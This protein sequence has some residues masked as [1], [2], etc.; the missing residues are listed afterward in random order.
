MHDYGQFCPLAMAA[1]I[2][3]L[4]WMPLVIRELH[5]GSIRF[6]D[7]HRGIPRMSRSLLSR[8][9]GELE[10]AGL[11]ERRVVDGHPEYHPTRA[12]ED[13]RP[14]LAQLGAWGKRWIRSEISREHLDAGRLMWEVQ[15]RVARDL[16]PPRRVV[17]H[18]LFPDAPEGD[19]RW[20]LVLKPETV[21][22][23]L[24]D[25]GFAWDLEVTS[26][27]RSLAEVWT[28][29]V[30]F[31]RALRDGSVRIRGPR[32]LRRH[33]PRWIGLAPAAVAE[34]TD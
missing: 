9:L 29:N 34:R 2:V 23:C 3:T 14:I 7:I 25:P 31:S 30:D 33:L 24:A 20:W 21:D 19:R 22:L 1:E 4:R 32:E 16:L 15:R 11:V 13:L 18:F 17:V 12:G 28:G 8:R 27:V 10:R 26:E 5:T 6:N